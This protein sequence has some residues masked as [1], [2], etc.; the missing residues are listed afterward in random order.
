MRRL[1]LQDLEAGRAV[2]GFQGAVAKI[3]QDLDDEVTDH[4]L[5]LDDENGL[6][7]VG[8]ERVREPAGDRLFLGGSAIAAAGRS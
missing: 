3:L 5:I 2:G 1:R 7:S 8:P 4:R 6:A